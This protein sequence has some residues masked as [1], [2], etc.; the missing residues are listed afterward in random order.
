MKLKIILSVLLVLISGV[1]LLHAERVIS[2]APS[3]T[4]ILFELGHGASLVGNTK[5]CN[6]PVEAIPV[7]KIG[8]YL[9]INT[10]MIIALKPDLIIHYPEHG[11]RLAPL[12][13]FAKTVQVSH[14]N[15]RDLLSSIR[16][17]AIALKA[18]E[19]G[20]ELIGRIRGEIDR[21]RRTTIETVRKKV[22][23][24][25]GRDPNRL[26]NITIIGKGDFLNEIIEIAGGKNAYPG[27]ISYPTVSIEAIIKMDP[28]LII[29]FSFQ[30]K[31][32]VEESEKDVWMNVPHIRAV[33]G[34]KIFIIRDDF[35]V[36]PGPRI[37]RI[38][39]VLSSMLL[40]D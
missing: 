19:E 14:T 28:D 7:K 22:L 32:P 36:R 29:E 33:T 31:G 20:D 16:T 26:G 40:S 5:F 38:A 27:D 34:N 12:K 17:I 3:I 11:A 25:I 1:S 23:I 30:K 35:W 8:G 9:D 6:Y 39:E 21:I 18:E 37:G 4:E 15:I 10:E 2:L 13:K 24:V